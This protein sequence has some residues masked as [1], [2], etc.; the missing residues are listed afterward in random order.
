MNE[1]G[2]PNKTYRAPDHQRKGLHAS[3]L[4]LYIYNTC[5]RRI[6]NH[7]RPTIK[8]EQHTTYVLMLCKRWT[9][10]SGMHV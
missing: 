8:D 1:I 2:R 5:K 10:F 4:N 9:T 6:V 3:S 7:E